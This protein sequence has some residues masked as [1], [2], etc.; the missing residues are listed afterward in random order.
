VLFLAFL[1]LRASNRNGWV[2]SSVSGQEAPA[3]Q[4]ADRQWQIANQGAVTSFVHLYGVK[5]MKCG[6]W[7]AEY[8]VVTQGTGFVDLYGVKVL[9]PES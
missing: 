5:A 3:G 6:M 7:S 9:S 1:A 8:G 4:I 2:R